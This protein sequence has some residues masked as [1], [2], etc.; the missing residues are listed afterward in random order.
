[1]PR[2]RNLE[3]AISDCP[4][5]YTYY[6]FDA[7]ELNGFSRVPLVPEADRDLYPVRSE[8]QVQAR[9]LR[10]VLDEHVPA[11]TQIDFLSVDV[12]GH[13]LEVLRSNDWDR[14]RPRA[15]VTEAAGLNLEQAASSPVSEMM[16]GLGY[17][18]V[19]K[20][21]NSIVFMESDAWAKQWADLSQ[22]SR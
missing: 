6:E 17:V 18:L 15:V 8:R 11:G 10:D 2:D 5:A 12:E 22:D 7:P 19:S 16:R 3:L 9:R 20:A 4:G 21:V 13:D 14:F 1:R